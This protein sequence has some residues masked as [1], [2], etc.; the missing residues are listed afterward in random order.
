MIIMRKLNILLVTCLV[1]T[2]SLNAQSDEKEKIRYYPEQGDFGIGIDGTPIFDY[3]GN[4]FNGTNNNSLNIGDQTLYFRYFLT[5]ETAVRLRFHFR[6]HRHT[7]KEYVLDDAARMLDENSTKQLEDM[8]IVREQDY[9]VAVGYQYFI[10]YR[11]VRGFFGGDLGYGREREKIEYQYGNTMNELNP[12]PTSKFGAAPNGRYLEQHKGVVNS[13][14]IGAFTGAEYY[15]H[16][17]MCIGGELGISYGV[18]F[19]GQTWVSYETLDGAKR[20]EY[21]EAVKPKS[22]FSWTETGFPY[23]YGNLYFVIHF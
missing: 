5:D 14:F 17:K 13:F 23:T 16:P 8:E 1:L 20:V 10:D 6:N 9:K 15:F 22:K 7:N 21:D 3:L 2:V 11:R 18:E 4:L 19:T 12:T